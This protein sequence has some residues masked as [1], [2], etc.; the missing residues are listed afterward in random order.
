MRV[1]GGNVFGNRFCDVDIQVEATDLK[2]LFKDVNMLVA[3]SA[4]GIDQLVS[5]FS[6]ITFL[7]ASLLIHGLTKRSANRSSRLKI[8]QDRSSCRVLHLR[9]LLSDKLWV[10]PSGML[11]RSR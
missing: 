3:L 8:A 1:R 4:T 10:T 7:I 9:G 5:S 6:A 11:A 2:H